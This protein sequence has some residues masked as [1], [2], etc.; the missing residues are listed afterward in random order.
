MKYLINQQCP[1]F[2][3][4]A[5]MP[6]DT[7]Q[8]DFRL[9]DYLAAKYGVLFFYPLDF[10][11]ISWTELLSVHKRIG[12][13]AKQ[14]AAIVAISCDSHLAHHTW[15]NIPVENNGLGLMAFPLVSDMTRAIARSFDVLV[16]E[17]MTEAATI[18]VDREN[19]I[20]FQVRHDT[21]VGRNIDRILKAIAILEDEDAPDNAPIDQILQL[22]KKAPELQRM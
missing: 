6:D 2:V 1:D 11:Y 12:Q 13:F 8:S 17:A 4:P 21:A 10:N 15:K 19:K 14:D 9:S 7:L 20:M 3:A 22:D 16:A 18:I 5:L